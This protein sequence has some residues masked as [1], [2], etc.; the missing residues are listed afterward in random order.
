VAVPRGVE[1]TA[2]LPVLVFLHG[3][4]GDHRDPFDQLDL[5]SALQAWTVGGGR[6][7]AIA[8]VDGADAWWKPQ[9]DGTDAGR[10]VVEEFVPLLRGRG[11]DVDSLALGGVSMGGYGA[12][13]L[14]GSRRLP[15]R[16]VSVI[17]PALGRPIYRSGPLTDVSQHP[18]RLRGIPVQLVVGDQDGFLE[19]D[20]AFVDAMRNVG[21]SVQAKTFPGGHT[22]AAMKASVPEV[23]RFVGEHLTA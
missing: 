1:Q 13:R 23:V 17:A 22:S 12:L 5:H 14:A 16:N 9:S 4:G 10:M 7:F 6:P 18:D 21:V 19:D 20:M 11:L 2:A 3:L 8:T 15:V